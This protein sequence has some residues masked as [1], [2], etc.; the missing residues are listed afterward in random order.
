MT[1]GNKFYNAWTMTRPNERH[2]Q[3]ESLPEETREAWE[4]AARYYENYRIG[5]I[6]FA[7]INY[8]MIEGK[9][10]SFD[11]MTVTVIAK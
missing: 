8:E 4:V 9:V 1:L 2:A 7:V 10:T 3:W 5:T 11:P 6:A